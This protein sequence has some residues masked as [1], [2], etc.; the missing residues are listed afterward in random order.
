MEPWIKNLR[1]VASQIPDQSRQIYYYNGSDPKNM[2]VGG[3]FKSVNGLTLFTL[4]K[5][6]HS[7]LRGDTQTLKQLVTDMA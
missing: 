6:G 1:D 2:V 5:A 7:A 3:Y 4:P